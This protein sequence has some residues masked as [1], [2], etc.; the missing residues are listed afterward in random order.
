MIDNPEQ[1]AFPAQAAWLRKLPFI[2]SS[3]SLSACYLH[4]KQLEFH[5]LHHHRYGLSR[6]IVSQTG[7]G[8]GGHQK[9]H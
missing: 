7:L 6:G 1:Q 4:T 5:E 8:C 9:G 2:L 3:F